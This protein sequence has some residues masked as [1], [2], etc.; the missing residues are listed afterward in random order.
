[1]L[2]DHALLKANPSNYHIGLLFVWFPPNTDNFNDL[3]SK[4]PVIQD[5]DS[6]RFLHQPKSRQPAKKLLLQATAWGISPRDLSISSFPKKPFPYFPWNFLWYDA[7]RTARFLVWFY[8]LK[9]RRYSIA[10]KHD[11]PPPMKGGESVKTFT[12]WKAHQ[13]SELQLHKRSC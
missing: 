8:C 1:M 3:C 13:V 11:E 4:C 5:T 12:P 9:E 6:S 2:L 10:S 7:N